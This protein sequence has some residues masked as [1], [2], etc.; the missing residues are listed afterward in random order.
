MALWES[1]HIASE[2]FQV[3]RT[4]HSMSGDPDPRF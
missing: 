3:P 2:L 4:D 1:F